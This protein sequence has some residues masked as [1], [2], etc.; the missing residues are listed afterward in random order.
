MAGK[1]KI[2]RSIYF[3]FDDSGATARNLTV[4]LV[5]GSLTGGGVTLEQVDMT[6]VSDTIKKALGGYGDSPV[7][8]RF[9]MDDTA[10]TGAYTVLK[11]MVG[12]SGTLTIQF[13]SSG[14]APTTLDPEWEGEYTLMQCNAVVDSGRILLDCMWLPQSGA[15][16]PAWGTVT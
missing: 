2:E 12:L 4:D 3:F 16:D 15:A 9:Y 14:S 5:P 1:N 10:T 6:G 8:G 7:S 13:G 11:G